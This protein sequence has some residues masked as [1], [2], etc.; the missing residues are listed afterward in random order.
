MNYYFRD[1]SGYSDRIRVWIRPLQIRIRQKDQDPDPSHS[2][3][4]CKFTIIY[5]LPLS[6]L[7]G[8]IIGI[9]RAFCRAV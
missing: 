7:D 1:E 3:Q 2:T 4:T 5:W 6:N 9:Y 8:L